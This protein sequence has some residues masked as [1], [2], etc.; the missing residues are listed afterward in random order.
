MTLQGLRMRTEYMMAVI[1]EQ[2]VEDTLKKFKAA[3]EAY[4]RNGYDNGETVKLVHELERLG[5]DPEYVF[6]LDFDIR[7]RVA[8]EQRKENAHD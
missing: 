1:R 2:A 6:E 3:A 4:Y 5:V 8:R 7:D